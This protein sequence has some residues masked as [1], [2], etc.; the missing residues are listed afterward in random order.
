MIGQRDVTIDSFHVERTAFSGLYCAHEYSYETRVPSNVK[1]T[2]GEVRDAG[3][4]VDP[5]GKTSVK[6]GISYMRT[7]SVE[8]SDIRVLM[9]EDRGVSG[10]LQEFTWQE[11][12][13]AE[14]SES[15]GT[16]TLK[17][18]EVQGAADTGFN[19]VGGTNILE[20]LTA[21]EVGGTGIYVGDSELL[22]YGS[23]T[24]VNT[25]QRGD[26]H[27]AFSFARNDRVEGTELR[28]VDSQAPPTGYKIHTR[29]TQS[30]HLGETR[31]EVANGSLVAENRSSLRIGS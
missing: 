11:G 19:L 26:P 6:Y 8:F 3:R 13:G 24:A 16:V 2:N 29:G 4:I 30:G 10:E 17:N 12:D 28:I 31:D 25:S 14:V 5:A 7:H 21:R 1:F 22:R 23:L 15:G 20:D 27:R 18:I 9:P